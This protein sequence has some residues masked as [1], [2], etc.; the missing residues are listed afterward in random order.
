METDAFNQDWRNLVGTLYAN[1]PWNLVSRVLQK[2]QEQ[3]V[4][5]IIIAPVWETQPWYVI[6]NQMLADFPAIIPEMDNLMNPSHPLATPG[7][8]P[9]LAVW[10][11]S[12]NISEKREF[13]KKAQSCFWNLGDKSP[14]LMTQ[15]SKNGLAGVINDIQIPFQDLWGK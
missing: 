11:V 6:L 8:K 14:N 15:C 9:Q 12:G 13:Q 2:I 4:Q 10:P 5:V 3:R 7:I 1:P